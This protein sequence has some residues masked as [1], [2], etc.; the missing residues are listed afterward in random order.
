MNKNWQAGQKLISATSELA[1]NNGAEFIVVNIPIR[2]QIYDP[3]GILINRQLNARR[4][5]Q[6]LVTS[7]IAFCDLENTLA[8]KPA[9]V[10]LKYDAHF[11]KLGNIYAAKGIE[12]CLIDLNLLKKVNLAY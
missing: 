11:T 10:Y 5:G 1:K 2:E 4:L 12:K 3:R 6:F 9:E 7:S 8:E